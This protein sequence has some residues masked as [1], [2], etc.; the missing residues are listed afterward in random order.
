MANKEIILDVSVIIDLWLGENSFENTE[1]LI[2]TAVNR[3]FGLWIAASSLPTLDYV[4]RR[5]FKHKGQPSAEVPRMVSRLIENLLSFT[6]VLTCYGFEQQ[7]IYE[8]ARDFEDAQIAACAR[9]LA[10]ADVC[11]VTED[12]KF[13]TLGEIVARTPMEALEW[14]NDEAGNSRKT[15]PFVDLAT[16]QRTIRPQLERRIHQVLHHGKYIMGPEI[17][18]LEQELSAFTGAKHCIACSSGTDA[19]LLSLMALDIGPGDE[20]ITTPFTFIATGEMIA[21]L[22]ATPVFVDIDETTYNIDPTLIEQAITDKTKAIMPVSLYGQ[23]ADMDE[24]NALAAKHDLAVIEDAAQSF[25]A[26]YKGRQSC[27]LSSIGC[28]SFFPAKP[29][30]CYGDGGAVFTSDD[31]LAEKMRMLRVHGQ[32]KRYRHKYIGVGARM[33]TIQAAILLAKLGH[34][35]DE[36]KKR[37]QIA[38]VYTELLEEHVITP[39]VKDDRTSVWAQYS[40]RVKDRDKV[41]AKLKDAGIPTAVHYPMPLHLQECFQYLGLKTGAFPVAETVSKEIMSLPMH[42]FLTREEQEYIAGRMVLKF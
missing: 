20:V 42:P 26:T 4:G 35:P 1:N 3:G 37:Q 30:G 16:Q 12:K 36:I 34:Y 23:P 19:L 11:I 5:A 14:L 27:N 2:D 9:S 13:D 29:L 25:G 41:Q 21:H 32:N 8:S 6:A 7:K 10:G 38:A 31:D 18:E 33:D 40:I 15:I 17:H 24:I 39:A 28:T 22:G